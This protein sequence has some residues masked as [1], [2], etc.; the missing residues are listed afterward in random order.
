MQ[1]RNSHLSCHRSPSLPM[2][3]GH[4]KNI[5]A[6]SRKHLSYFIVISMI[7]NEFEQSYS[8]M[9]YVYIYVIADQAKISSFFMHS[10]LHGLAIL[11]SLYCRASFQISP[12]FPISLPL[13]NVWFYFIFGT[14][15]YFQCCKSKK[16]VPSWS[17]HL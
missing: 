8:I 7:T 6:K 16:R 12:W 5:P 11:T 1:E 15:V 9:D 2:Q 4:A 14:K 13:F 3:T 17:K 10:M